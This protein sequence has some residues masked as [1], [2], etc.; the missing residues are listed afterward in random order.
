MNWPNR[1]L[2]SSRVGIKT[3]EEASIKI[4]NSSAYGRSF[5]NTFIGYMDVAEQE[6]LLGQNNSS[7]ANNGE[8]YLSIL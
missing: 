7:Q 1:L 5:Q 6:N 2:I 4:P 3:T 8:S